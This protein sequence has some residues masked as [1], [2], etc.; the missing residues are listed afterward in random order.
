MF[1]ATVIVDQDGRVAWS[2]GGLASPVEKNVEHSELIEKL[3][4]EIEKL[5]TR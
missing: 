2:A 3:E 1:P 5:K 4:R